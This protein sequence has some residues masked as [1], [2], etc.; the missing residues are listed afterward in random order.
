MEISEGS[1]KW[2][3]AA[4]CS[5]RVMATCGQIYE[6]RIKVHSQKAQSGCICCI[7]HLNDQN[8]S[9]LPRAPVLYG[10][11]CLCCRHMLR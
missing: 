1:A 5:S 11:D 7:R 9:K 8:L 10:V 3:F 2:H 4:V 6:S